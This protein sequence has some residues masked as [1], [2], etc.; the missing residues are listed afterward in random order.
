MNTA[1]I[2]P[3]WISWLPLRDDDDCARVSH[4]FLAELI[5]AKN[6]AVEQQMASIMGALPTILAPESNLATPEVQQRIR[7]GLAQ[8]YGCTV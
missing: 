5:E 6:P 8:G 3:S 1:E 4:A 2:L 7:Q